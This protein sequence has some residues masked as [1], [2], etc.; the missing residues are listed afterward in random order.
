MDVINFFLILLNLKKLTLF[1]LYSNDK[2]EV[3]RA[4]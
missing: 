3:E 1:F 4:F 2:I